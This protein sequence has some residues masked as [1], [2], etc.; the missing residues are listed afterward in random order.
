MEPEKKPKRIVSKAEY[1]RIQSLRFGLF[2][3]GLSL[4]ILLLSH[5]VIGRRLFPGDHIIVFAVGQIMAMFLA[6]PVGKLLK[7]SWALGNV[8]PVTRANTGDLPAIESLVRASQEPTQEQQSILLRA[9]A[10]TNQTPAEQL[11]RPV[12][13]TITNGVK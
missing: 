4:V 6:R 9:A 10:D 5:G 2:L 3:S 13:E 7:K 1:A 12:P 8:V 11:L